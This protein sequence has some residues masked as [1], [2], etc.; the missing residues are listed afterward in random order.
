M[1]I[2]YT[3]LLLI[4]YTN[5]VVRLHSCTSYIHDHGSATGISY[6]GTL[7]KCCVTCYMS[8]SVIVKSTTYNTYLAVLVRT[9]KHQLCNTID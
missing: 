8:C 1:H 7:F 4:L 9:Y 3:I 6:H 2:H 5:H